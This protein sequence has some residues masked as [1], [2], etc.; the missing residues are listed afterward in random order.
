MLSSDLEDDDVYDHRHSRRAS[1]GM[2]ANRF[3]RYL[4]FAR[5]RRS[6]LRQEMEHEEVVAEPNAPIPP[7]T[8][9]RES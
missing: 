5:R 4:R 8:V 2:L 6:R 9:T 1:Q 7:E 3:S